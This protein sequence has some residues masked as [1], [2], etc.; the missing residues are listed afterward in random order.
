MA[1]AVITAF[2]NGVPED[3]KNTVNEAVRNVWAIDQLSINKSNSDY[4]YI[5]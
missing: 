4:D 3:D 1:R 5:S 2:L